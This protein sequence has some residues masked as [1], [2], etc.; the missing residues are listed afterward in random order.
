MQ[1]SLA[2]AQ[3]KKIEWA[4]WLDAWAWESHSLRE[5]S[6]PRV[7]LQLNVLLRSY[8]ARLKGGNT[9]KAPGNWLCKER[10]KAF[11]RPTR[12]RKTVLSSNYQQATSRKYM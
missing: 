11:S 7:A 9:Q 5:G 10:E 1:I 3:K 8:T 4:R 2:L 12:R 6:G